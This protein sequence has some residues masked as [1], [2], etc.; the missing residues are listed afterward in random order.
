MTQWIKCS[1]R[2]PEKAGLYLTYGKTKLVRI[3]RFQC[4]NRF[5]QILQHR[6]LKFLGGD[7]RVDNSVTHWQSLPEPPNN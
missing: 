2:L 3:K 7:G 4:K 5:S 1:E 6:Q